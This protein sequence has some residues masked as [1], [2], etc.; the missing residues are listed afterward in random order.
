[1]YELESSLCA[2]GPDLC[3]VIAAAERFYKAGKAPAT[4]KAFESDLASFSAFTTRNNLPISTPI[5]A[6]QTPSHRA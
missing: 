1:M 4:I 5:Q 2:P 6:A 3:D